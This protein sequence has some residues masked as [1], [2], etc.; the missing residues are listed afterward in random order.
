MI[1]Y[2]DDIKTI[3]KLVSSESDLL[4][5]Q[6]KKDGLDVDVKIVIDNENS[7]VGYG[8]KIKY[9][10]IDLS[11]FNNVLPSIQKQFNQNI[12]IDKSKSNYFNAIIRNIKNYI[13]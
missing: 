6:L 1:F 5:E 2:F 11:N 7:L 3:S 9:D 13:Q 4:R 10:N 12:D 8:I